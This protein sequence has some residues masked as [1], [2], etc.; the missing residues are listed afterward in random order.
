MS[1]E[2]TGP[3]RLTFA[4]P[5]TRAMV[6]LLAVMAAVFVPQVLAPP[7]A[8]FAH[9]YLALNT[10]TFL[11]KLYLWQAV[12]S[13]FLHAGVA[14]FMGNMIFLWFFGSAL[15]NAWRPREFLTFFLACGIAASLCFFALNVWR[16]APGSAG[17]TGMGASGAVFGLMIAYAIIFGERMVL[18]FFLIPMKA[19]HFVAICF[20]IEVLL[21]WA[22]TRDGVG[23]VA[24]A[25][26]AVCGM[27]Y[28]K[29]AWRRQAR[30]TMRTRRRAPA[31]SRIGGLELMESDDD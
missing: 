12:T 27:A 10:A 2:P 7:F 19:K 15:A 8:T 29:L 24:H 28:L 23:H 9:D 22:G 26:G 13:V 17:I 5:L 30:H 3:Y 11:G 18:A 1:S 21:L 25:G 4:E 20:A 14:H 6:V 31:Q 16:A